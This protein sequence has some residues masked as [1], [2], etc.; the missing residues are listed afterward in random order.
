MNEE[1]NTTGQAKS[2]DGVIPVTLLVIQNLLIGWLIS[3][4][5][6]HATNARH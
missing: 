4:N 1:A 3:L 2:P 6:R 5:W